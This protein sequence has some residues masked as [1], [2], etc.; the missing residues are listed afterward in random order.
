MTAVSLFHLL[1]EP[2]RPPVV[3]FS[4]ENLPSG[5]IADHWLAQV[6]DVDYL[7]VFWFWFPR[8][9]DL[10]HVFHEVFQRVHQLCIRRTSQELQWFDRFRT[11]G[12]GGIRDY[13]RD[14]VS[15]GEV[16]V[17]GRRVSMRR[18]H[19]ERR[20]FPSRLG[21]NHI[22]V[23][24]AVFHTNRRLDRTRHSRR[25]HHLPELVDIVCPI[26]AMLCPDIQK[27]IQSTVVLGVFLSIVGRSVAQQLDDKRLTGT[28]QGRK[29]RWRV[30]MIL[31]M[32]EQI[33]EQVQNMQS[34]PLS[35]SIRART[36]AVAVGQGAR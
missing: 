33:V 26:V 18:W 3:C 36:A 35:R 22:T 4:V 6:V 24:V 2:T 11:N 17:W 13:M 1:T 30:S 16:V 15:S 23:I 5:R 19:D 21:A 10:I 14:H 25:L 7:V 9:V 31:G 8:S 12:H 28:G 29:R 34:F 32:V 20:T 27:L